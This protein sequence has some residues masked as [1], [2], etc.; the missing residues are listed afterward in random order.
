M[1]SANREKV[2]RLMNEIDQ[3]RNKVDLLIADEDEGEITDDVDEMLTNL[4]EAWEA[5]D[6]AYFKL[7]DSMKY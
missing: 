5:L 2:M 4:G 1:K 7:Q 6:T 3:I